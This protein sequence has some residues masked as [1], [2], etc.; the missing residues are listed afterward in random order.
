MSHRAAI[1]L[2]ENGQIALV[3]RHRQG[4]HYF[5]FPGGH[6]E[7]A[8]TPEEAAIRETEEELGLQVTIKRLVAEIWWHDKP[9][10]YYLVEA[11]EGVFGTGT[12]EEMTQPQPDRGTYKPMWTPVR[13]LL[14]LSV[15]PRSLARI[16]VEAQSAG[17]PDPAPVLY[18]ED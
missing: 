10:Y 15:M 13:D 11:I 9:Q 12:G 18:D 1:I 4:L 5:T 6:I 3:E 14:N 17:W 8:E 16:V 7:P 2:I